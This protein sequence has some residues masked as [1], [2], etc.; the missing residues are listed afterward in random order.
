M[1]TWCDACEHV[2]PDTAKQPPWQWRCMKAPVAERGY[3]FVSQDYAPA[4]PYHKCD[5]VNADGECPMW[6]ARRVAPEKPK[7][8]A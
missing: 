3:R 8:A 2:H 5:F 1:T 6:Q 4:P 7:V